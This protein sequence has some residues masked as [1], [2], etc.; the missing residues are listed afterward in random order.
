MSGETILVIDAGQ[1]IDQRITATLEAKGYLV[2][3]DSSRV[4]TAEITEQLS[5]SL[6]YIKPPELSPAGFEP[7][8]AIH[9]TPLLKDV[10]IV[11]LGSPEEALHKKDEARYFREYGIVDFLELT[12]DPDELIKKTEEILSKVR[13]SQLNQDNT[14]AGEDHLIPQAVKGMGK[15][16]SPLLLPAIGAAILLVIVGAGFLIYQQFISTRKVVPLSAI[17]PRLSVPSTAP[18][19]GPKP[20]LP[21]EKNVKDASAPVSPSPPA[22]PAQDL[23]LPSAA[24]QPP[25]K[26]FYSVQ[27]GAFKNEDYAQV[28]TKKLRDKGYDAFTRPGLAADKSPIYRVLVCKYE[29]RKATE[30]LARE[31][32][33]KEQ[34]KTS[35]Y[36]E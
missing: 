26:P 11:I 12:F 36:S 35:L 4:V 19:T 29:D 15:K 18:E 33:S 8:K 20:L 32:E 2:F 30:K 6:I 16:R 14:L 23:S 13:S 1:D 22:P 31:I 3:T 28:L 10:P 34:L 17:K 5:P 21:P 24:S 9:G 27:L 25:A 7:C